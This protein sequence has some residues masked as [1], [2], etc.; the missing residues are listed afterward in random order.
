MTTT[1][2]TLSI[3]ETVGALGFAV[4]A[5]FYGFWLLIHHGFE[6]WDA[7]GLIVMFFIGSA[8]LRGCRNGS[9]ESNA[10]GAMTAIVG[11][12]LYRGAESVFIYHSLHP[13]MIIGWIFTAIFAYA[14]GAAI[15]I[16]LGK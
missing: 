5:D 6:F 3:R 4:V 2:K 12:C 7:I 10:S 16:S 1:D 11:I 13:M 15:A 9:R 14:V 8:A